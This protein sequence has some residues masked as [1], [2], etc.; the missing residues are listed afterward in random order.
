[1]L[2]LH[3]HMWSEAAI[4]HLT[5]TECERNIT[6]STIWWSVI[7]FRYLHF[8][9]QRSCAFSCPCAW[10]SFLLFLLQL[11]MIL[12]LLTSGKAS[13]VK[14]SAFKVA[15]VICSLV[16]LLRTLIAYLLVMIL[17][18]HGLL[19]TA[20]PHGHTY[21]EMR[22]GILGLTVV[23]YN[24]TRAATTPNQHCDSERAGNIRYLPTQV[25]REATYVLV[26]PPHVEI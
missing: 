20:M 17:I 7:P 15:S 8:S 19:R 11:Y 4:E 3:V 25:T 22:G 23:T 21:L 18:G 1:M 24:S 12:S 13:S 2:E 9:I 16:L 10:P 26:C 6:S 5:L 14:R